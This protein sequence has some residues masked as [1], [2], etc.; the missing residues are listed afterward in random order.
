MAQLGQLPSIGDTVEVELATSGDEEELAQVSLRVSELD[1]RRA[2]DFV[3]RRLD[4]GDFKP[5][6]S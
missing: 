3:V 5:M 6:Q 1:G 4:D 2:A